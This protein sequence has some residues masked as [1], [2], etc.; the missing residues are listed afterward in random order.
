[1][2][3]VDAKVLACLM[4]SCRE[5]PDKHCTFKTNIFTIQPRLYMSDAHRRKNIV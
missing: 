1:M 4:A 2:G 3:I 5:D